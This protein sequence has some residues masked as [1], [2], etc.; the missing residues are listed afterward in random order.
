MN[1]MESEQ[2]AELTADD[3][4]KLKDEKLGYGCLIFL[5]PSLLQYLRQNSC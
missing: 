5:I 2:I 1:R 4:V 3:I